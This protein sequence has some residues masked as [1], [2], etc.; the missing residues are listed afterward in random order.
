MLVR[1]RSTTMLGIDAVPVEVETDISQGLP[2]Y[3]VVGLPGGPVRESADRIRAAIRNS[4]LPFPGRKVTINL[5]PAD[6]RKDGAL[7]D[8]PIALSILCAEGAIPGDVL[9]K[10]LIAGEISLDGSLKP[11]RG[12]LS[13]GLLARRLGLSGIMVPSDNAAEASLVPG[14]DVLP[15]ATLRDAVSALT[16]DAASAGGL[17][18][19]GF[20]PMEETPFPDLREVVGQA[21]ARRALEISAAG[22]H[23]LLLI[24]PPGCGKTMLAERVPGI[25]PDFDEGEALETAQV[26]SAAG[27]PPWPRLITRRPFRVPHHTATPAGLI[28]GGNPPRPGEISFAHGGVLFLDEFSEFRR[29]AREA[30]RQPIES[31]EI[32]IARAGSV[33]R[34]PC[35]FLL[36]AAANPCPCG[37]LGHPRRIC[38]C[39]PPLLSRFAR[40]FSG[41]LLDRIDLSVS[42]LPMAGEDWGGAASGEDSATVRERVKRCRSI[43]ERRFAGRACRANGTARAAF[44]ELAS[45][46]SPEA[47]SFLTRAADRLGLSG[48]ALCKVCRVARTIADLAGEKSVSLPHVAEA[49]QYRLPDFAAHGEG[50]NGR[51]APA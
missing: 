26:Y 40:K 18:F 16:G 13:Q 31:G 50:K 4:G 30:L 15:A 1:A 20:P 5:A 49:V 8:L 38:R 32:R 21:V 27:E 19:N 41:P 9:G 25:L 14:I 6:I 28:G 47:R 46:L 17:H 7:L 12:V 24:G 37:N 36:V 33:Y 45:H 35:R 23:A 51:A 22:S 43:Q 3:T 44:S 39:P 10:H 34:F 29:E 48:R 11:V 42:V 2:S